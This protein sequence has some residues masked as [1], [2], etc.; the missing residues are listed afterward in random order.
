MSSR[1]TAHSAAYLA[2][3]IYAG[4][5]PDAALSAAFRQALGAAPNEAHPQLPS[6]NRGTELAK[7]AKAGKP[8]FDKASPRKAHIGPRSGHK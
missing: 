5:A 4:E 1:P 8:A 3:P 7:R 2:T 6:L